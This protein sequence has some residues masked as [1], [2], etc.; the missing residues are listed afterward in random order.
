MT[1]LT[2]KLGL[3]SCLAAAQE[4]AP[5]AFW[6]ILMLRDHNTRVVAL[7]VGCLGLAAGMIGCFLL[8][9]RRA[10]LADALSHATLP[11]LGLAFILLAGLGGTGKWLPGLL[12]GAAVSAGLGILCI[13]AILRL[14]RIQEDAALGVVLSVFFGLGIALAGLIQNLGR[15]QAAG[16]TSFIYGKTASML[17]SDALA[18]AAVAGLT[19]AICAALFKEFMLV[20]F[21]PGYARSRGW[22]V[23][24]LDLLMM[25]LASVV[26]VI[27]LQ[28]V[29]LVLVVAL[30]IIPPA[31]ARFWTQRLPVMFAISA[32]LGAWGC[33]VGAGL[34]A[35]L[36]RWPSGG[37]IVVVS[38]GLFAISL[39]LGPAGG[40][41]ARAMAR[42]RLGRKVARQHLLR[43]LYELTETPPAM[44]PDKARP[45]PIRFEQ[46]L[47]ARSWSPARLRRLLATARRAG[48][49]EG[50]DSDDRWTL[51]VG[52]LQAAWQVTRNH[53]LWELY[54]IAH[55]DIA[56]S[57]VDRDADQ[58]EHV[59]EPE[60]IARLESELSVRY[61]E[62]A[63]PP[64]P[65]ALQVEPAD[66]GDPIETR[67]CKTPT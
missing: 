1:V 66:A 10:L 33:L 25:V 51:T 56:P 62:L 23:L 15:G 22:P 30:L 67:T 36:P 65:H 7:G 18:M 50:P 44:Q 58:V 5:A 41:L 45:K 19:G 39:L 4:P 31:A 32:G 43:A 55:A 61:P 3:W 47:G 64:S 60:L 27:G 8:L 63:R 37:I 34:S 11:G 42:R 21:D 29:G 35:A 13:L 54:L 6:R 52:G 14:T 40:L 53:R 57:H 59:L 38:G 46:L 24:A 28:A 2:G 12:A 20:C 16:L 48:W 9:R 26:I 17:L 49:V